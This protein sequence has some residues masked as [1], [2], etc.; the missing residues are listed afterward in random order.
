MSTTSRATDEPIVE[1]DLT[2][3][4]DLLERRHA[5]RFDEASVV[6]WLR[7]SGGT[8]TERAMKAAAADLI[9]HQRTPTA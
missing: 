4:D 9:E 6:A 3:L 8:L 2:D 5:R 7:T 1:L